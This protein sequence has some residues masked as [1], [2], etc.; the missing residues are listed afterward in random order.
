MA[1]AFVPPD[2]DLAHP[3]VGKASKTAAAASLQCFL[4]QTCRVGRTL[5]LCIAVS[6]MFAEERILPMCNLGKSG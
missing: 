6:N 4:Y 1:A 5:R 3:K 2:F